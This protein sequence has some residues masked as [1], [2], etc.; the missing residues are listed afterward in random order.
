MTFPHVVPT[1][2][3]KIFLMLQLLW[4]KI[5]II[6]FLFHSYS[7]N[8]QVTWQIPCRDHCTV[9]AL[10][11]DWNI[12]LLHW[13]KGIWNALCM[14]FD[15]ATYSL[16]RLQ[17]LCRYLMSAVVKKLISIQQWKQLYVISF[18]WSL[19]CFLLSTRFESILFWRWIF[20]GVSEKR[21]MLLNIT[22][23]K[24]KKFWMS[25]Q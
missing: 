7:W 17:H 21:F 20:C 8:Q 6:S 13:G 1:S 9:D 11:R 5:K 24:N 23:H 25:T 19:W 14:L 10:F 3:V 15:K 22:F 2:L 4:I 18:H 16:K 12:Y